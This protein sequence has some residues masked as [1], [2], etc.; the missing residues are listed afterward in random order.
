MKKSKKVL[1]I[2]SWAT[3]G[4]YVL[5]CTMAI[6]LMMFPIPELPGWLND[7]RVLFLM[8]TLGFSILFSV[9]C[10]FALFGLGFNI[11]LLIAQIADKTE[12]RASRILLQCV[13]T[14]LSLAVSGALWYYV[15]AVF[16][17]TTGGA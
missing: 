1:S 14:V 6:L 2:L 15:V 16:V 13:R 3:H 17:W 4:A 11:S 12:K 8:L 10:P 7:V 5:V 9:F